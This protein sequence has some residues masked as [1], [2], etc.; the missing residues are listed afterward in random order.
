MKRC[1]LLFPLFMACT[2]AYALGTYSFTPLRATTQ[3]VISL[4]TDVTG[5]LLPLTGVVAVLPDEPAIEVRFFG[6][7]TACEPSLPGNTQT[8][9][10]QPLGTFAAGRYATRVYR[11]GFGPEGTVCNVVA[12]GSLVIRGD[13]GRRF[14]I[15]ALTREG[16]FVL[17]AVVAVLAWRGRRADC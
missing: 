13:D 4:R 7:D 12:A 16:L 5:C 3:Q 6:D 15:P 2:P 8:P 10:F 11:C 14:T 9:R 17:L 1:S